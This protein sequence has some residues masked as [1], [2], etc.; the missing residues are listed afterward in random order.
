MFFS[1]FNNSN[2]C[3]R[4]KA[5]SL[6]QHPVSAAHN[7]T[8]ATRSILCAGLKWQESFVLQ[9]V[10]ACCNVLQH[11]AVCCSMCCRS[12]LRYC[13][14]QQLFTIQRRNNTK[15]L[16]EQT[17]KRAIETETKTAGGRQGNEMCKCLVDSAL[18][19]RVIAWQE[20]TKTV[21]C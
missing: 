5:I 1:L 11:V 13:I 15:T 6:L 14:S 20:D 12:R 9:F 18:L 17:E 7:T 8:T 3:C 21:Q 19:S 2:N 4:N 10:A 16:I